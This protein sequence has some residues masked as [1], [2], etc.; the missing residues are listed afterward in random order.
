MTRPNFS[1]VAA[2]DDAVAEQ[3]RQ[4]QLTL[5]KPP[6]SL[7]R[8]EDLGVWLSACQGQVPPVPLEDIRL[9]V[10][11]GD[12]GV[13]SGGVSAY[14]TDVSIQMFHNINAGGAGV[15]AIART[16]GASVVAVDLC[17]DRDAEP[18]EVPYRVRRSCGSI[19]RE[20]A[21]TE[22]ELIRSLEVGAQLAD[23]AIDSG[24]QLLIAGDLGIGNTTPAAAM[25][26]NVTG[27][28]P[29]VVVGRG[30]GIDDE[31]W[32]RKTAAIRDAMFRVRG[33]RNDPMTVLRRISS[34]D[35]AAT[36]AFLARAAERRTPCVLDGVVVTSAALLADQ[37]S[38]GA[39]AW[40]LA[41]HLSAEPAHA[42][43][44]RHLELEPLVEYRMRL[45]E[46]SGAVTA[47]PMLHHAVAIMR[48]MATFD[49]AGVS[50][51]LDE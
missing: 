19:D 43:A 31:G 1:P 46:G 24:A 15:N 32:K 16:S 21:M 28:E 3:A 22:D 37:L 6:G 41:G 33:V 5:T 38:P 42:I 17:L 11:A 40:W 25:I 26:G 8:L 13:A 14:P 36:A 10:F 39:R 30:S 2:P 9:V 45:G 47:V 20:D 4:F 50:R 12:H 27:T 35:L 44:L 51:G 48:D 18:G 23:E 34:P 7:G 29:V 49:S